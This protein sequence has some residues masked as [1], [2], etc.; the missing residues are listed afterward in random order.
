M[1]QW[2]TKLF[3]RLG[4][5]DKVREETSDGSPKC[6]TTMCLFHILSLSFQIFQIVKVKVK[7]KGWGGAKVNSENVSMGSL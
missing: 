3:T 6:F 2:V 7:A 4:E 1:G 5:K